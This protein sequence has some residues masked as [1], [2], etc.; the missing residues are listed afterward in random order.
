MMSHGSYHSSVVNATSRMAWIALGGNLGP[1]ADTLRRA[2]GWLD[3]IGAVRVMAASPFLETLPVG[4]PQPPY[5]NAVARLETALPPCRLLWV[6]QTL[7]RA[8]G[9]HRA[10]RWGPR[11]LD[12]DLLVIDRL[13]VDS[14]A[15]TL[16]H[17]RLHERRFVLEPWALLDP[18]LVVPRLDRSVKDLL[19][20]LPA[21]ERPP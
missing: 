19:E 5:L 13:V 15:L 6:L 21:C 9:R 12:L 10:E 3:A 11:T 8:A 1:V 4:P 17:P 18:D 16:P 7:E 20:A 2:L 14:E